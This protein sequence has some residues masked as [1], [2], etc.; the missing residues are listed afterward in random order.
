MNIKIL[1]ESLKAVYAA[2]CNSDTCLAVVS[3]SE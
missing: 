2:E 1:N 3:T